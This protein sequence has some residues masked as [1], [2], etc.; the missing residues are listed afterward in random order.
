MH[1]W[2]WNS[3]LSTPAVVYKWTCGMSSA[4]NNAKLQFL[5]N[6]TRHRLHSQH[7]GLSHSR[8][9]AASTP[10]YGIADYAFR[11]TLPLYHSTSTAYLTTASLCNR[12]R[13]HY[14]PVIPHSH[15]LL[16]AVTGCK[17]KLEHPPTTSPLDHPTRLQLPKA[18]S[19]ISP[20]L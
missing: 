5:G 8:A 2:G 9:S 7:L 10:T 18:A 4:D 20:K 17:P 19:I 1:S 13:Q 15:E 12:S 16:P 11:R 3:P 14:E 6:I